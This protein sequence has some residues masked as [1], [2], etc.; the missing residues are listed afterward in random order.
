MDTTLVIKVGYRGGAFAGY[1][2]QEGQRTVAGELRYAL[3]TLFRRPCELVCAGRTDAGVHALAQYVSVPVTREE[4]DER[5][6]HLHRSLA[7]ITPED[8]SIRGL[9]EADA[10]FSARFDAMARAYRYRIACGN[11]QPVFGWDHSWWLRAPQSLDIDA[12]NE[13][14]GHLLGEHDFRSFCKTSS[15]ETIL[16]DGRSTSRCL[17]KLQVSAVTEVGEDYVVLDVEGNAFLHNMVRA[18]TG[19]LV[20][21]GSGRR[22]PSWV[23]EALAA[24]N[25]AAA[26]PTA[27][28]CGLTLER[29]DYPQS[30]LRIL[31]STLLEG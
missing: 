7:A 12:M 26:G 27:P 4:L 2:E 8:I 24:C 23:A 17:T 30:A 31:P 18:I 22:S 14:A 28:A 16:A 19:T 21:V 29:V 3:E 15:A 1:A 10:G 9:Y 11:V 6:A 25:R 5:L 13:A 20:E